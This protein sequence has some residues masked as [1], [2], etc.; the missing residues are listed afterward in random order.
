MRAAQVTSGAQQ[1][2]GRHLS[3]GTTAWRPWAPPVGRPR[4]AQPLPH[5]SPHAP[6]PGPPLVYD[7][8]IRCAVRERT[9]SDAPQAI[10]GSMKTC[11]R[12]TW[13]DISPKKLYK[14]QISTREDS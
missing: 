7:P 13:T 8:H 12:K 3:W 1:G 11:G 2:E 10:L 9:L 6:P 5:R 4:T 14:W